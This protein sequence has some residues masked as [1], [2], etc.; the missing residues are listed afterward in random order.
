MNEFNPILNNPYEE[1]QK[2]YETSAVDGSLDYENI[3]KGRRA[4]IPYLNP[5]PKKKGSQGH[6][7]STKEFEDAYSYTLIN[8]IRKEISGWRNSGYNNFSDVTRVTKDY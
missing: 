2:Y 1:P 5:I 3:V 7:Y 6:L 4:F 8:K